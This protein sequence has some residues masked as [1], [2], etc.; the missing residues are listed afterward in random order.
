MIKVQV[1]FYSMYGHVYQLAEAV[2]EGV[3]NVDDC[4]VQLLQVPDLMPEDALEKSDAKAARQSFAHIPVAR[5]EILKK[6]MLSF[7][8]HRSVSGPCA[9]NCVTFWT[10]PPSWGCRE[11]LS[12][13]AA[14]FL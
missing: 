14:V 2:A 4:E 12:G 8:G 3:K 7:S 13:K 1:V 9:H 10:Q 11:P 6:R 5:S